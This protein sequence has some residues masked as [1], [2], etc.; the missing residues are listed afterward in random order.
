MPIPSQIPPATFV[1]LPLQNAQEYI[2]TKDINPYKITSINAEHDSFSIVPAE[3]YDA[4]YEHNTIS[5]TTH[6]FRFS[7]RIELDFVLSSEFYQVIQRGSRNHQGNIIMLYLATNNHR[8]A[9][10][11]SGTTLVYIDTAIPDFAALEIINAY[12]TKYPSDLITPK[13]ID[14]DGSD[15]YLK[16]EV[17][18]VQ[19]GTSLIA[20]TDICL[21]DFPPYQNKQYSSRKGITAPDGLLEGMCTTD[22]YLPGHIDEHACP[23]G[24]ENGACKIN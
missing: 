4:K 18:R 13:C 3:R 10:W 12:L 19:I 14:T 17:T 16:G 23:R 15:H 6:V 21:R 24:C 8:I 20:W 22:T 5:V 9:V 7:T 2:I 1:K 11:S